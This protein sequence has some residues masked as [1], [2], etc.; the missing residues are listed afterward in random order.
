MQVESGRTLEGHVL[1]EVSGTVGSVSL[2]TGASV[3]PDTDGGGLGRGVGLGG[4]GEAVLED[5]G[6]GDGR[7]GDGGGQ[8]SEGG[9]EGGG[10]D[11]VGPGRPE[12]GLGEETCSRHGGGVE[13]SRVG[14]VVEKGGSEERK[15]GVSRTRSDWAGLSF[16]W[17]E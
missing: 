10:R 9:G 2:G 5:G 11:L 7:A 4:D 17:T 1:E 3:D 16:A 8:A 12:G 15:D 14:R 13:S 6:L